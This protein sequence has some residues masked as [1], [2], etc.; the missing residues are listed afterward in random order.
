MGVDED[1]EPWAVGV[2]SPDDPERMVKVL[3]VSDRAV[4]T[5]GTY[6]RG[7]HL[8]DPHTGKP[9]RT[10]TRSLTV[11]AST[12]MAADAGATAV[13]GAPTGTR[14]RILAAGA[15]GARIAHQI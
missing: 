13:F 15:P 11:E 1:G 8:L 4:A 7:H 6:F 2:R 5:S 3:R 14:D 10:P 12:C 9:M